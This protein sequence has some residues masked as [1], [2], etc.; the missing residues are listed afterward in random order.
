MKM[1]VEAVLDASAVL[2]FINEESGGEEVARL[3]SVSMLCSVNAS[4]IA[5]KLF[6]KRW[7]DERVRTTLETLGCIH[8]DADLELAI[9]AG[10]LRPATRHLGLSLGDRYCLALARREALPVYTADRRWMEFADQVD[11]RLIR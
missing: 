1:A 9:V 6:E 7:S 2:A 3:L 4:E 10:A 11:I 8:V 5:A